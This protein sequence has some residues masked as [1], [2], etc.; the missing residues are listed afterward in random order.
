VKQVERVVAAASKDREPVAAASKGA[1]KTDSGAQE[2]L[3]AHLDAHSVHGYA[4]V[5]DVRI[6]GFAGGPQLQTHYITSQ[7]KVDARVAVAVQVNAG[8]T[9]SKVCIS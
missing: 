3:L 7:C 1:A 2:L 6:S 5:K 4:R 8:R 9:F